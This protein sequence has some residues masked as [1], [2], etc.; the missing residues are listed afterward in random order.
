MD[1]YILD[2]RSVKIGTQVLWNKAI[3]D[4]LDEIK[5]FSTQETKDIYWE[6]I[7]HER[8]QDKTTFRS[9]QDVYRS[10]QAS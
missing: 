2:I 1:K 10:F 6:I 7:I 9:F 8:D 3:F 5:V 4:S